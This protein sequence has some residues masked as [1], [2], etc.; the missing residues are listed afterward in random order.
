[1]PATQL[2]RA[3]HR[4]GPRRTSEFGKLK[5]SEPKAAKQLRNTKPNLKE[6]VNKMRKEIITLVTA[7]SCLTTFVS[8]ALADHKSGHHSSS[9]NHASSSGGHSLGSKG[10]KSGGKSGGNSSDSLSEII[11]IVRDVVNR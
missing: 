1:V 2:F 7:L 3:I 11:G 10:G 4:I 8:P 5:L 9:G 6:R